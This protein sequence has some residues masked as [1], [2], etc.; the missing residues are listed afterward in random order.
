MNSRP[1]I[2]RF[3]SGSVTPA[4]AVRNAFG[5]VHHVQLDPGR[6]H[7]VLLDLLG[8]ALAQQP[9][10]DEHAGQPGADGP[11]HQRRG[12]RRVHAAGQPADRA[13]VADLRADALDLLLDDAARRPGRAGSPRRVQEPAQH[14]P[15][16][17]RCACTSGWNC[18]PYSPGR[19]PRWRRP[20]SPPVRGG[21]GEARAAAASRC[22]RATST[23]AAAPGRPAEQACRRRRGSG[24]QRRSRRTRA[25]PVCATVAAEAR[26]PSA[27]SRSRCRTPGPRPAKAVGAGGAPV[28]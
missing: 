6:G 23:P 13:A 16:R 24:V 18:T 1:M 11:L 4:S 21:D 12:D 10:V 3:S 9:V 2:L 15:C 14:L 5:R 22:R 28:A 19:R 25:A 27:G 7:E 26:P 8:L 20:A 17:A